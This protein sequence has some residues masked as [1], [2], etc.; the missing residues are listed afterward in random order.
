MGRKNRTLLRRLN[1][2]NPSKAKVNRACTE[3]IVLVS[4]GKIDQALAKVDEGEELVARMPTPP[5]NSQENTWR[6][7]R[8]LLVRHEPKEA[9]GPPTDTHL[10][11]AQQ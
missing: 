5:P 1:S 9:Q 8:A 4:E 10:C 2:G 3:V 11:G 6:E 7:L